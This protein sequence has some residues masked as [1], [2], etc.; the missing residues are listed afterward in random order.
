MQALSH[1]TYHVSGGQFVLCDLQGGVYDKGVVLTDP[2]ILSRTRTYG[3]TDLG[4][5][6]ISSFFSQ[7][8]CNEFCRGHWTKPKDTTCYLDPQQGT[9]MAAHNVPT[10]RGQPH[11]SA[12]HEEEEQ[13]YSSSSSDDYQW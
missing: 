10:L 8:R 13:G 4:A 3:V 6:G 7:H 5:K 1:F 12:V 2:V 9:S 11:M